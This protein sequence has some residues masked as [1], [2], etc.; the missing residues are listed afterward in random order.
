MF[1]TS[2]NGDEVLFY[3]DPRKG[4]ERHSTTEAEDMV[5]TTKHTTDLSDSFDAD[6]IQISF[7]KLDEK[8]Q[9]VIEDMVIK[10]VTESFSGFFERLP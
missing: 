7:L 1:V 5:M 6:G 4:S 8:G 9:R 10:S 3:G 2:P